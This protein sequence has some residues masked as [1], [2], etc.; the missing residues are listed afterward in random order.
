M[1]TYTDR[2]STWSGALVLGLV[3][4]AACKDPRAGAR[5]AGDESGA[6]GP[7]WRTYSPPQWPDAKL[8]AGH[9]G[10]GPSPYFM[11][12][13]VSTSEVLAS[14]A[15]RA[16][17]EK[18]GDAIDA[19]VVVQAM[20]NVVE[21]QSSGIGGGGLWLVHLADTDET[22]VIDCR[23]RAPAGATPDMFTSEPSLD[24]KSS[25]GIAVGVPGTLH[26]M[27]AAL[28]LRPGGLTLAQALQPA[29][30]AA[31]AGTVISE[32]LADDSE[33]SRLGFE[34]KDPAYQEARAVFRPGGDALVPGAILKQ[35]ALADAFKRVQQGGLAAFYDCAHPA[36][37]ADAIVA[38]QKHT[39][40]GYPEGA[41]RMTCA[42]LAT[43]APVITAPLVGR[44]RGYT[45]VTTPPPSSGI[46]LLQM[47]GTLERFDLGKG[48][49]G[50]GS[51]KTMNVMQEAMRL[52]F[53]DRSMWLGDPDAV[54]LPL[55]GLLAPAYLAQRSA[56]IVPGE[57]QPDIDPGDPRLFEPLPID[58][59]PPGD[60]K[61]PELEGTHTSHYVVADGH[62]NVV[63]VTTTITDK[64]GTGLMVEDFGFL[65]NDQL[66]NFNDEPTADDSPY[67]PGA[68]DI[69]PFKRPRTALT[70]TMIFL[71]DAPI[72]AFGS[73]G[74]GSIL[75][76][77]LGF[78]VDLVD[79]RMTLQQAVAAPRFSL[80]SSN[81]PWDTE[82]E[83]GFD[84]DVRAA[85]G[86][87]GY[88]FLTTSAI[89]AVQAV[90][91]NR[92]DARK[93]ATAD[94]RRGGAVSGL[95]P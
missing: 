17:L 89:G 64:W 48:E 23:E 49:Y 85:L 59:A 90:I 70:P 18:G 43:F 38:T 37:V 14:K 46:S 10:P 60:E 66:L 45:I 8:Q 69:A 44:Y 12:G 63:S 51:F 25:S 68:N 75:N 81:D 2:T 67:D 3:C 52:A 91:V 57:R 65:L 19:A 84:P 35:P 15:G 36:G 54:K 29:I 95:A 21:P 27:R 20:L 83:P 55:Q 62:G 47:L 40:S 58:G 13:V 24:R 86:K 53:A 30:D 79:H 73:P 56:L 42:D 7:A 6:A 80:C 39:R 22:L 50:F 1:S 28:D 82:I 76:T 94:P 88:D 87:L 31:T 77:V 4:A 11:G 32:R 41:G 71:G 92:H 61:P 33:S 93:Y 72:A 74:G 16:V 34:S 78:L 5:D 26:C 9:P